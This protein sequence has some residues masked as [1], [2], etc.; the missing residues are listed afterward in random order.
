MFKMFNA[1][2]SES[3]LFFFNLRF[4]SFVVQ[5]PTVSPVYFFFRPPKGFFVLSSNVS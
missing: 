3:W 4:Y 2:K 1:E 5:L